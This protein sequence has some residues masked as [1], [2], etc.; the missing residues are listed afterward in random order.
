MQSWKD[1]ISSI[2]FFIQFILL[3]SYDKNRRKNVYSKVFNSFWL[4]FTCYIN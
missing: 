3:I 1:K 2:Q 4:V